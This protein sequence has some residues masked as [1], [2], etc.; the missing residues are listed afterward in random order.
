M[1]RNK[2]KPSPP[3]GRLP[4]DER[5][6]PGLNDGAASDDTVEPAE[7]QRRQSALAP[8]K[9]KVIDRIRVLIQR[10]RLRPGDRLPTE[11]ELAEEFE[12]SRPTV[13]SALQSLSAMG[14][15]SSRKGTGTFIQGG[16]PTL[17]GEPLRLLAD[18][19]DFGSEEMFEA[20][21]ALEVTAAGLA[22]TR[23]SA[24]QREQM[25]TELAGMFGAIDAPEV[26]LAHDIRFHRSVAA[27]SNNAVLG[28]LVE[29]VSSLVWERRRKTIK[30]AEDLR[31]SAEM[32]RRIFDAIRARESAKA[33]TAMAVHLRLALEGWAAEAARVSA[34]EAVLR[35]KARVRHQAI[36]PK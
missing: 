33:R 35:N 22:A 27:A 24:S 15:V 10:R 9:A 36:L 23:A 8:V 5:I 18:L 12:V 19:H 20:R 13:R 4:I 21:G 1:R 29:M 16:P 30:E 34:R 2:R 14:V 7:A 17:G 3:A 26:F 28:A 31:E 25:A 6:R 11:R 32:H